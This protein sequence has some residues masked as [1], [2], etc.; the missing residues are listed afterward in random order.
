MYLNT[1]TIRAGRLWRRVEK[2]VGLGH[3]VSISDSLE[4][5]F[6]D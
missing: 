2:Y 5:R 6:V 3:L 4:I 1:N